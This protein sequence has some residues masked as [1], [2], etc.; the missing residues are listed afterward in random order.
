MSTRIRVV[1]AAGLL[2]LALLAIVFVGSD[3]TSCLGPL[4]RTYVQSLA[5]G[6]IKPG[7]GLP[8]PVGIAFVLAALLLLEPPSRRAVRSRIGLAGVLAVVSVGAYL[9]TRPTSLTGATSTGAVITVQLPVD[10]AMV[11]VAGLVA[12]GVGWFGS[13]WIAPR[14][15]SSLVAVALA[16]AITGCGTSYR[17]ENPTRPLGPGERWLPVFPVAM[18][19]GTQILCGGVGF[20]GN[21]V[22]RG[23]AADP[24][25]AWVIQPDGRRME[26]V[27]PAGYSA[28]FTPQ[29]E[30]LDETSQVVARE[31][32]IA[33]GGC[34]MPP[35]LHAQ[36]VSFEAPQP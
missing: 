14:P 17:Y 27:W 20:V 25:Q 16:I 5:D 10:V 22:L 13:R 30:V 23:S 8:V 3:V 33:T 2:L 7:I 29:L 6:C 11:A 12:G 4:G 31:G 19:D 34:P 35:D 32:S 36:W 28:R 9:V 21:F 24:R 1:G 15:S 18:S 26:L